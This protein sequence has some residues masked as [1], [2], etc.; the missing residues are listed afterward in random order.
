MAKPASKWGYPLAR[1]YIKSLGKTHSPELLEA[2]WI[3]SSN[4]LRVVEKT[5]PEE[6]DNKERT[7]IKEG[8]CLKSCSGIL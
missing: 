5:V 2:K 1:R 3:S 6:G 4:N 7:A 8:W